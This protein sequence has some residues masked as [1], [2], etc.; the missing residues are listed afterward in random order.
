MNP[1]IGQHVIVVFKNGH[2]VFGEVVA[3]GE[4]AVLKHSEVTT[5]VIP[6]VSSEVLYYKIRNADA[7]EK[8]KDKPVK[9]NDDIKALAELKAELNSLEK[10][11]IVSKLSTH[12]ISEVKQVQYKTPMIN[13]LNMM[14]KNEKK[15]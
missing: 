8:I 12:E 9:T 1:E 7:Y 13:S 3:W 6:D 11:E 4:K 15:R 2:Q 5:I 14:F 10:E